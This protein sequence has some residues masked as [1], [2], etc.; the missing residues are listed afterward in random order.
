MATNEKLNLI[1][2]ISETRYE[3]KE[4]IDSLLNDVDDAVER[5]MFADIQRYSINN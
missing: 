5:V 1:S 3:L 2:R 4:Y